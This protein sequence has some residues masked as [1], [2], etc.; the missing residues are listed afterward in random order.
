M[1]S[2]EV[3]LGEVGERRARAVLEKKGQ[4]LSRGTPYPDSNGLKIHLKDEAN[5]QEKYLM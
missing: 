5:T 1:E 2:G 3:K 4:N